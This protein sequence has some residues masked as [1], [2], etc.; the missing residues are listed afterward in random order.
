MRVVLLILLLSLLVAPTLAFAD[1]GTAGITP[2]APHEFVGKVDRAVD[3]VYKT[4]QPLAD[5][6][7]KV[8][9]AAGGIVA[10]LVL[11][12]GLKLLWRVVWAALAVGLGLLLFYNAPLIVAAVKGASAWFAGQ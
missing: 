10:L 7:G 8:M 9:L 11:V 1:E 4:A 2:V 12:S 3:A 5:G 6:L